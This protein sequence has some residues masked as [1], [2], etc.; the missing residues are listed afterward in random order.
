MLKEQRVPQGKEV[1]TSADSLSH[2]A[3]RLWIVKPRFSS[4][5][6]N[7]GVSTV[8]GKECSEL[9]IRKGHLSVKCKK[10]SVQSPCGYR[11][12]KENL[13]SSKEIKEKILLQ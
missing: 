1:V 7:N 9:W 13:A 12:V 10:A 4:F 6:F 3:S 2:K 11:Q 8:E 5:G